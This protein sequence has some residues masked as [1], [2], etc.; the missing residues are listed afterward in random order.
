VSSEAALILD[1][2][3]KLNSGMRSVVDY[4]KRYATIALAST[5]RVHDAIP[6][7]RKLSVSEDNPAVS[8]LK[9]D[10]MLWKLVTQPKNDETRSKLVQAAVMLEKGQEG[11]KAL[12][13]TVWFLANEPALASISSALLIRFRDYIHFNRIDD[14]RLKEEAE[15]IIKIRGNIRQLRRRRGA[16]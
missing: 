1:D 14:D 11:M 4:I 12:L 8:R 7:L 13:D 9:Q 10:K 6:V 15:E 2:I 3:V 5:F 16:A